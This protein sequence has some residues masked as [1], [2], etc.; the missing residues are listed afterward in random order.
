[1]RKRSALHL[2]WGITLC[3][4]GLGF[5]ACGDGSGSRD[6]D[7]GGAGGMPGLPTSSESPSVTA[8]T[9]QQP[10]DLPTMPPSQPS[11]TPTDGA[12]GS[13]SQDP[14]PDAGSA[15]GAGGDAP[16]TPTC[17]VLPVRVFARS[18]TDAAWDDN[19]FSDAL[20]ETGCP[21]LVDVTWPH[22]EG[23][24]D[25]DPSD[26]NFEQTHITLDSYYS[27]D[28][29]DKQ[30]NLTIELT[31]DM[32]GPNATN[33]G[34]YIVSLVSVSTYDQEVVVE[35]PPPSIDVDAG[36]ASDAGVLDELP[37]ASVVDAAVM[38][39]WVDA[40]SD[41]DS[42]MEPETI[43]QT[44]YSEAE[45]PP[46]QRLLLRHVG[47]RATITFPLPHK[48]QD[49]DSYDPAR[50]I[51]INIRIYNMFGF[52]G[53]ISEPDDEM[54]ELGE[55]PDPTHELMADAGLMDASTA[56]DAGVVLSD[57]STTPD[58]PTPVQVYDYLSSQ[59][60]IHTFA[61]TDRGVTP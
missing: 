56:L 17:N 57:A 28:L 25:A 37:D 48:T 49:V 42:E 6:T 9:P 16:M 51:K 5:T 21:T 50:V 33:L 38:D 30:L 52:E 29:T 32:K 24:K 58:E 54:S 15:G 44:G 22:E 26:A 41:V 10:T 19:D 46:E 3:C 2:G 35:P 11:M 59:F 7:A 4:C 61:V 60:A 34:G 47:D 14:M 39:D 1:M 8:T 43:I 53:L 12:G 40:G 20:I 27:T 31:D 55:A 13:S 36:L 23:W 18:D 45:T